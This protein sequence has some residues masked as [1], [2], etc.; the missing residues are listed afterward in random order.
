MA[1]DIRATVSCSLG[2]VISGSISDDYVQDSGL[3]RSTGSVEINDLITPAIGTVVTFSYTKNGIF[4]KIPRKFRVKSSFADPFRRTTQVEFGCKLDYLSD[5]KDK[6]SWDAFDDPQ[7]DDRTREEERVV[8]VPIYAKSVMDKCLAELGITASTN[9][10]TNVFSIAEFDFSSGYVSVL[11][12]LLVSESYCGYLDENEVLQI[13]A[14]DQ[15]AGT[16]PAITA[17]DIIDLSPIGVGELPGEAVTVTYSSLRLRRPEIVPPENPTPEEEEEEEEFLKRINWEETI[18]VNSPQNYYVNYV[19]AINPDRG[20]K[21]RKTYTGAESTE[22]LT[23]Y[24]VITYVDEEGEPK[25][26]EVPYK[27]IITTYGPSVAKLAS[28]AAEYLAIGYSFPND[29]IALSIVEEFYYYDDNKGNQ[30]GSITYKFEPAASI[31]ASISY[32]WTYPK[33]RSNPEIVAEPI[34]YSI[35]LTEYTY[36]VSDYV[37]SGDFG[38]PYKRDSISTYLKGPLSQDGQQQ[39]ADYQEAVGVL[40]SADGT[41][42]RLD[43]LGWG[44]VHENT[45]QTF[46]RTGENSAQQRP[47]AAERTNTANAK[48][49][50]GNPW[51]TESRAQLELAV[52]SA[53]AQRRIELS[54]PYASDDIF[55]N[56]SG[57]NPVQFSFDPYLSPPPYTWYNA[58][59]V[60]GI[61]KYVLGGIEYTQGGG[62]YPQDTNSIQQVRNTGASNPTYTSVRSDAAIKANRYGR[63]QNRLRLGNRNGISLQLAPEKLPAAP[64]SPLY[65]QANGLTALYR[66]NGTNWA[67]DSNGIICSVDALFWGAVGGT[68]VFWFPVAPGIVTLPETPP[69]NDTSPTA[70]I[71]TIETVGATP[72][73]AL[74]AAFP[75]AGPGDG[76]QDQTTTNFWV[77]GGATWTDVGPNPGPQITTQNIVLPY[78]ETAIY[79]ARLR[80]IPV[81]TSFNFDLQPFTAISPLVLRTRAEVF[82]VTLLAANVGEL[83]LTGQDAVMVRRYRLTSAGTSFVATGLSAGSIRAYTIGTNVGTFS[84]TGN[85]ADLLVTR[86]LSDIE[87]GTFDLIGQEA[88]LEVLIA[89]SADLGEFMVDGQPATLDKDSTIESSAASYTVSGGDA[90]L[91]VNYVLT[92]DAEN[93]ALLGQDAVLVTVIELLADPGSFV[94][95]GGEAGGA[96][97]RKLVSEAANYSLAGQNISLEVGDYFSSWSSQTYG[98][99]SLVYP[100]WWA[101]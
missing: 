18:E 4:N 32:K 98:Y 60:N 76:V 67:F 79:D 30:T 20:Q 28:A 2:P 47:P 36:N 59:L 71:G 29:T 51:G 91:V 45:K 94:L 74:N 37:Y 6:L 46:S 70:V 95:T 12:D 85:T 93:F 13:F 77:Y 64:Y 89:I 23:L 10:L 62:T 19:R 54:L 68:G 83:M 14:L 96:T 82:D 44:L 50:N 8:T 11:N 31:L 73:A 58:T 9:P 53:T 41:E 65:V 72:Q 27:K 86:A 66:A 26:K 22:T 90:G 25:E 101:D 16:G 84:S 87:A 49:N 61:W 21:S 97:V 39:I 69:V 42:L 57:Q 100:D 52:G 99:Q 24:K 3:I 15:E 81:V 43:I 75:G 34:D 88:G 63:V 17:D 1:N 80:V 7:N 48:D 92:A 5:L 33:S 78:N 56:G 55:I 40:Y 35:Y 38:N